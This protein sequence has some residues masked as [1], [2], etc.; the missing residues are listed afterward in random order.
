MT[1]T[2]KLEDAITKSGLKK[3]IIAE[4]LGINRAT[5]TRKIKNQAEFKASEIALLSEILSFSPAEKDAIF[6][7][8]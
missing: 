6:Y 2:E 8:Q 1:H 4:R 5:L 3:Y 7:K